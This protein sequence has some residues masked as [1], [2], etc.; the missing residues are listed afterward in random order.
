MRALLLAM[1]LLAPAQ[2]GGKPLPPNAHV[3]SA[4]NMFIDL[5]NHLRTAALGDEDSLPEYRSEVKA[6]REAKE[7]AK[8]PAVWSLINDACIAGPDIAT[9]ARVREHLPASL[10]PADQEA[11]R[12]MIG[13]LESAWPRFTTQDGVDRRRSLE[14]VWSKVLIKHWTLVE[15]RLLTTVYEK[16]EFQP[17]S[18]KLTVYP[19]L[20]TVRL[21]QWGETAE[22]YYVIVPVARQPNLMIL[23][24]ILHE[25]THVLGDCQPP[26]S[27]SLLARLQL[28]AARADKQALDQFTE[29]LVAWNS[30]EMI[31]RFVSMDYT[32]LVKLSPSM[33]DPVK[34]Y[35]PTYEGPWT[36]YLDGK[37]SADDAIKGMAGAL[38]PALAPARAQGGSKSPG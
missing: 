9:I 36:A 30:G 38:K 35:L 13:A 11:V 8:D 29:G 22:G 23:E 4:V 28:A 24:S 6:F 1:A 37:I 2:A 3:Q 31:R 10:G 17:L 5:N 7:M 20:D 15:Q 21:G 26:G 33:R 27:A 18:K 14:R 25:V 34:A 12:K 19:V 16:F 32:P